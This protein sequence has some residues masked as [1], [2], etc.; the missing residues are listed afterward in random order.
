MTEHK[1]A[2]AFPEGFIWGSATAAAQIEGAA[3]E[4]GK[5]DSGICPCKAFPYP[6]GTIGTIPVCLP[7]HV[8]KGA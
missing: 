3:H 6:A 4:G 2:G 5:E 7:R 1:L 8:G